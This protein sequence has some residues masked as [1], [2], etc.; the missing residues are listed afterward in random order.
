MKRF[1]LILATIVLF[2]GT[3][4]CAGKFVNANK[5]TLAQDIPTWGWY[6]YYTPGEKD[7]T[8]DSGVKYWT[9]IIKERRAELRNEGCK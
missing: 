2:L 7:A 3:T 4:S 5:P 9:P 1:V 6:W 8:L